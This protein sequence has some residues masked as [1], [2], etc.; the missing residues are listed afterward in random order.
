MSLSVWLPGL[1]FFLEGLCPGGSL[2][3]GSLSGA[4]SLSRGVP[5]RDP[6]YGEE[7]AV[8]ILL[9]CIL[10]TDVHSSINCR[11][12]NVLGGVG[13]GWVYLRPV[14]TRHV[15][16]HVGDLSSAH[17]HRCRV[18]FLQF[19]KCHSFKALLSRLSN[20]R[21]DSYTVLKWV[22]HLISVF[23]NVYIYMVVT[24]KTFA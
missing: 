13:D 14:G 24:R 8:H 2:S 17:R 20:I 5:D 9:E 16:P 11:C 21:S 12:N 4:M 3:R 19:V 10:I 1:V 22:I 23:R 7:L 18:V 6:L 15:F